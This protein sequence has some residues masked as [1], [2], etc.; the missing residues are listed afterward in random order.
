MRSECPPWRRNSGI[1][2]RGDPDGGQA[3]GHSK[4]AS[5]PKR[6]R[7]KAEITVARF[8]GTAERR[9]LLDQLKLRTGVLPYVTDMRSGART[10]SLRGGG[11]AASDFD[12]V[13]D[14]LEP[15]WRG[16]VARPTSRV[17][18]ADQP[19]GQFLGD[20]PR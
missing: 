3:R 15:D 4:P 5:G 2:R 10:Y 13:L 1:D 18:P 16:H 17:G 6:N 9:A 11:A 19:L 8:R 14:E 20:F 7:G 12:P